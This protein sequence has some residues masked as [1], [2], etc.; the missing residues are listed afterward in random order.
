MRDLLK[1]LRVFLEQIRDRLD[2]IQYEIGR[3][4]LDQ[5]EIFLNEVKK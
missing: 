4:H 2:I 3:Y 1:D 5:L